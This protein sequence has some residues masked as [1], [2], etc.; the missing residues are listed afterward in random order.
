M[1]S[2]CLISKLQ[3]EQTKRGMQH[4]RLRCKCSGAMFYIS[5]YA[6]MCVRVCM[7]ILLLFRHGWPTLFV[8]TLYCKRFEAV[9]MLQQYS[10]A[11]PFATLSSFVVWI[12]CC[13]FFVC[14][15]RFMQMEAANCMRQ[16]QPQPTSCK[17]TV[18]EAGMI[19]WW[20]RRWPVHI[21]VRFNCK[22]D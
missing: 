19:G 20:W 17:H 4:K 7:Q 10:F 1:H 12:C 3:Q 5:A 13:I 22:K 18:A 2:W 21:V 11:R 6:C 15:A 9:T 16:P 14:S 8:V